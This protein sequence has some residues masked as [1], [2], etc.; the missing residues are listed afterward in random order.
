LQV[1]SSSIEEA[2]KTE[3]QQAEAKAAAR[4]V[5]TQTVHAAAAALNVGGSTSESHRQGAVRVEIDDRRSKFKRALPRRS[6]RPCEVDQAAIA[7]RAGRKLRRR[8]PVL[9]DLI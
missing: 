3:G 7:R 9:Q 2:E 8:E 1:K 6:H 5:L 4:I